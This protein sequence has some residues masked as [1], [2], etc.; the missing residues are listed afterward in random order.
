MEGAD[1]RGQQPLN[2]AARKGN[3]AG[4][5]RKQSITT[6]TAQTTQDSVEFERPTLGEP[7][8]SSAL[9]AIKMF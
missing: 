5:P 1:S 3:A 9:V 2:A 4:R 8:R 7:S 6:T